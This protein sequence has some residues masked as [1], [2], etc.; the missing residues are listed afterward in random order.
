M[1][2]E[3]YARSLRYDVTTTAR[4]LREADAP[5]SA[6]R[7]AEKA[8]LALVE[9][10]A[11]LLQARVDDGRLRDGHGDLRP[12]H[13]FLGT[14]PALIDAIEFSADLRRIDPLDEISYLAMECAFL[15]GPAW[16]LRFVDFYAREAEDNAPEELIHFYMARRAMLRAKLAL[17]HLRDA[18]VSDPAKWRQRAGIY[19]D[20][21]NAQAARL[22]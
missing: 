15:G 20:L 10:R 1:P 12:E 17:W 14:P 16:G 19:L 11:A 8:L 2:S 6:V 3:T 7:G 4:E 9:R 18:D 13:V 5:E 22:I 21:A